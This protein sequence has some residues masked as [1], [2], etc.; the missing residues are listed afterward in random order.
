MPLRAREKTA[1][2]RP[3]W[4]LATANML[5]MDS[6]VNFQITMLLGTGVAF[7]LPVVLGLLGWLG[8]VSARAMWRFNRYAVVLAVAAAAV[9]TPGTDIHA[10]L[11]LA[12][13]LY[14]L[15]NLSIAVV[16]LI[17]RRRTAREAES[18]LLILVAAWPIARR[19]GWALR[20]RANA[21][22]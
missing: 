17:E 2:S 6:M 11:I 16:W 9:L 1:D 13:P 5:T 10:Q 18:P 8:L 15:Y 12:G 7:E 20:G 14:V 3:S 22:A 4:A 21:P 19:A